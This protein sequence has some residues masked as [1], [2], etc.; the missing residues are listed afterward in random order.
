MVKPIWQYDID[1]WIGLD[2][3]ISWKSKEEL[4][5]NKNQEDNAQV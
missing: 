4:Y 5:A 3:C 2:E 1:K